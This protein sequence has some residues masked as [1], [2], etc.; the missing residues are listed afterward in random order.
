MLTPLLPSFTLLLFLL[1]LLSA[2]HHHLN[3]RILH[4]P[5]FPTTTTSLSPSQSPTTSPIRHSLSTLPFSTPSS[6]TSSPTDDTALPFFPTTTPPPPQPPSPPPPTPTPTTLSIPTFPAN[7]SSLSLPTTS[8]SHHHSSHTILIISLVSVSVIVTVVFLLLLR[9]KNSRS[10]SELRPLYPHST[11]TSDGLPPSKPPTTAHHVSHTSS[12]FLYLGTMAETSTVEPIYHLKLCSASPDLHPLP[13]LSSELN[14]IRRVSP[15]RHGGEEE[16]F[17]PSNSSRHDFGHENDYFNNSEMLK[18]CFSSTE[19]DSPGR[20]SDVSVEIQALAEKAEFVPAPPPPPA[21]MRGKGGPPTLVAPS[22]PVVM[23]RSGNLG[24]SGERSE[25]SGGGGGSGGVKPKLKAL[26]WDKV[27]ASSD[28]VTVWDQLHPGSFTLNEEMIETLFTANGAKD[29]A[30]RSMLPLLNGEYRVLDPKKSQ[31]IAIL[32]KALSV[33]EKEVCEAL[34]E[35]NADALGVELLESLLKMAPTKEEERKLVEYRDES[36]MRLG[37]AENFLRAVLNVPFAF[38][39]VDAMLYMATFDSDVEYLKKAFET[40]EAACEQLRNSRVFLKLIEAV[41]KTGNRMN[42][43]TN[44]G[45]AQAF[46]LDTLLKLIDIKGRDGKTT[47]LHFVVQEIIKA[48]G[49]RS[50]QVGADQSAVP[51]QIE[52]RKRGLEVVSSL[53]GELMNV[54]KAAAMDSDVLSTDVSKLTRDIT[55]INEVLMLSDENQMM[56]INKRFV[57]SM[58]VFLKKSEVEIGLIQ[59]QERNAFAKVKELTEYFHGNLSKEEAHPFRIFTVVRDF[60]GV[61]DQVCKEVGKINER[62]V[63]SSVRQYPTSVNPAIQPPFP[64]F[65]ISSDGDSSS[66]NENENENIVKA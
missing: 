32:L 61:L 49:S 21:M 33:T 57:E 45:D 37:P 41:L 38:R 18:S 36:P 58:T 50:S 7:V 24:L 42:V 15:A 65:I 12:D 2:T 55:K 43:G 13:P 29:G 62:T 9:R 16:F 47:L 5:F 64:E 25:G 22:G 11:P 28:R 44:R 59:S 3:R 40:L 35:G 56:E 26:Y 34:L 60:L 20:D 66:E 53:G 23:K 63:I 1:P 8:P 31:N 19:H 30:R 10:S 51:D 4:L 27:R 46:K 48:E 54:K 14:H 52:S 39:R 6:P 17:S